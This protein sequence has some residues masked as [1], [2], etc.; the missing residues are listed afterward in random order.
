MGISGQTLRDSYHLGQTIAQDYGRPYEPGVNNI[1]GF[2]TLNE[3][4]VFALRPRRISARALFLRLLH[5]PGHLQ[6]VHSHWPGEELIRHRRDQYCNP[7]N[8]NQATIPAGP[9]AAQNPFRLQ[10]ATLSFHVLGH[11]I[12]GGKSDSWDGPGMGSAM[13]WSNNAED[14]YSFRINRVEPLHIPSSRT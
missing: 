2:A 1:T 6:S 7:Y 3:W 12:S 14:I 10:E 13:N 5:Q 4:Q 11:E 9:I 8:A